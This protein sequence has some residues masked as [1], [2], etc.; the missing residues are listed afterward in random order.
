MTERPRTWQSFKIK[1]WITGK[2]SV[3]RQEFTQSE[4]VQKK[5][6][7]W[8]RRGK[9]N[10]ASLILNLRDGRDGS[11]GV[12]DGSGKRGGRSGRMG[13]ERCWSVGEKRSPPMKTGVLAGEKGR[14]AHSNRVREDKPWGGCGIG[15]PRT[16][17][18]DW[19]TEGWGH[20]GLRLMEKGEWKWG[21]RAGEIL[22]A[23]HVWVL[24]L[25][26]NR[27]K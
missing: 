2:C 23:I 5:N 1:A 13:R 18:A 12:G 19:L 15:P 9:G 4:G 7:V 16:F 24:F 11:D 26:G 20:A 25:S 21:G 10:P 22:G 6:S 14:Q 17:E 27:R 8:R 3:A